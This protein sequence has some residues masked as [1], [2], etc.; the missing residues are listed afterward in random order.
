MCPGVCIIAEFKLQGGVIQL[1]CWAFYIYMREIFKVLVEVL[2]V[3]M[4]PKEGNTLSD[5]QVQSQHSLS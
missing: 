3:R 1:L 5:Y 4:A 2:F